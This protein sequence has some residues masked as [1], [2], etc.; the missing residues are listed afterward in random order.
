MA[1]VLAPLT[2]LREM[3]CSEQGRTGTC[4]EETQ[5]GT[6]T[7]AYKPLHAWPGLS[8]LQDTLSPTRAV[9]A[10]QPQPCPPNTLARDQLTDTAERNRGE[11]QT[12]K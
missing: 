1:A 5:G 4:R 2:E 12:D 11:R 9:Q 3:P 7:T 6:E 8:Q 10:A